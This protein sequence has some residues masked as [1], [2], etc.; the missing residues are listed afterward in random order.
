MTIYYL[1]LICLNN[2]N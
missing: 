1:I 2:N